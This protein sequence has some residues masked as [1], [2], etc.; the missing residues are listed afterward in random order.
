MTF[1][2]SS[3]HQQCCVRDSFFNSLR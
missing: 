3:L 1:S 2:S